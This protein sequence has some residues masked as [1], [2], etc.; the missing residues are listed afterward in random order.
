MNTCPLTS[1]S[2]APVCSAAFVA[3]VLAVSVWRAAFRILT[4][5]ILFWSSC[6]SISFADWVVKPSLPTWMV[7]FS[8]FNS[9]L[10]CRFIRVVILL[11]FFLL[12][13][14]SQRDA[15]LPA[16]AEAGYHN[17]GLPFLSYANAAVLSIHEE[18]VAVLAC[19]SPEVYGQSDFG[20]HGDF[21]RRAN[22]ASGQFRTC[23]VD[24]FCL[25]EEN[26]NALFCYLL[27]G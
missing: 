5:T 25:L 22:V 15:G 26:A 16:A 11:N 10:T 14:L 17:V 8:S 9:C 6:L 4:F 24:G 27:C 13:L 23:R 21:S 2:D 18:R 3:M 20:C 1:T 7:G 19:S 12:L